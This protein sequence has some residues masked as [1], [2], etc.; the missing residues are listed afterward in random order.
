MEFAAVFLVGLMG[1][2]GHC[3][4]MCGGFVA[5]YSLKTLPDKVGGPGALLATAVP[6]LLYNSGRL[7]T[8]IALGAVAALAAGS[9]QQ[10]GGF[11]YFQ[12]TLLI[13]AGL[14]M[15]QVALNAAGWWPRFRAAAGKH[16][17]LWRFLKPF[18]LG[19]KWRHYF[20]LG[21]VLGFIP[22]GFL[23]AIL[24]GAASSGDPVVAGFTMLAF[25]LGTAPAL[26]ALGAGVNTVP[27]LWRQ[28]FFK[29][30]AIMVIVLG[31]VT[32]GRGVMAFSNLNSQEAVT[33]MEMECHD[34]P[35]EHAMSGGNS[36]EQE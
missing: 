17:L 18:M 25:G 12:A 5:A 4:G 10:L 36:D 26:I 19:K 28:R 30:A 22:C 35:Q 11:R 33:G 29:T 14:I 20:G 13:V 3:V 6:H 9:L 32:A 23:Y 24:A 2:L 1:S 21:F 16:T 34:M 27:V 8:Y 7:T 31:V 15:I